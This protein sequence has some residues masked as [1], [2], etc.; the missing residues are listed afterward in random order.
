[1]FWTSLKHQISPLY[2][3]HI[4]AFESS[5]HYSRHVLFIL[6]EANVFKSHFQTFYWI[7]L[8]YQ[9]SGKILFMVQNIFWI[10]TFLNH[11]VTL[12]Q[13]ACNHHLVLENISYSKLNILKRKMIMFQFLLF[14]KNKIILC[15]IL[16]I[17]W[18]IS[19][20]QSL[21]LICIIMLFQRVCIVS[22]PPPPYWYTQFWVVLI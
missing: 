16:I 17:A 13:A 2:L 11:S 20:I 18:Y 7:I 9:V 19:M 21:G 4:W 3:R 12:E 1:M 5:R 14:S 8:H 15:L 22:F 6:F 10:I